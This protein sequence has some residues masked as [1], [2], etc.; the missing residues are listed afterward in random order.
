MAPARLHRLVDDDVL[1]YFRKAED[2]E[3]GASEYRGAGGPLAVSALRSKNEI[4]EAF[5]E[6]AKELKYLDR[7]FQWRIPRKGVGPLDLPV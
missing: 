2:H 6:G 1:P 3:A 4:N 5:I 7:R